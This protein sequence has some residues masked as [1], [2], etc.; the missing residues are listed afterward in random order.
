MRDRWVSVRV[1]GDFACFTRPENK[2]ER[3]SYPI[4]TPSAARGILEAVFWHPQFTWAIR[5]IHAM[6]PV[7]TYSILRNEVNSKMSPDRK[8]PFFV[9]DD[10]TQRHAVCLRDVDYAIFADIEVKPGVGD[11]HAKFRDQFRRRVERGQCYHRP[12]LGCR[13]FAAEFQPHD[14]CKPIE[15]TDDLGLMLWDL[16]Y[17]S[18]RAPYWPKFFN[19]K[20][21]G[22]VMAVPSSPL[23]SEA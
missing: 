22:G 11:D 7:R 1:T 20:V 18:G 3:V 14:G 4:M 17:E 16:S 8:E 19:A 9:D 23:G 6:T 2:V 5:E 15:W 13:E 12:A 10:R 21:N